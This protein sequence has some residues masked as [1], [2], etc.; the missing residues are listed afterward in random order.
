VWY[1]SWGQVIMEEFISMP[2]MWTQ[3]SGRR[4]FRVWE[5]IGNVPVSI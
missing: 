4:S 2:R 1:I 5:F 3:I